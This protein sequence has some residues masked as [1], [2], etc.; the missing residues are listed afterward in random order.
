MKWDYWI[1]HMLEIEEEIYQEEK[2]KQKAS[3]K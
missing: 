1:E 3:V 2:E